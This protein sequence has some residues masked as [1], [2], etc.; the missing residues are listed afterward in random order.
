[1]ILEITYIY[2]ADRYSEPLVSWMYFHSKSDDFQKSITQAGKHFKKKCRDNGWSRQVKLKSIQLISSQHE[3]PTIL[4]VA[5]PE[6]TKRR[7]S[8][9][10]PSKRTS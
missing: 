5:P 3:K 9:R 1:M 4:T 8:K 6:S 7:R 2:K 10:S